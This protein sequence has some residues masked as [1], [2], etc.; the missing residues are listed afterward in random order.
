MGRNSPVGGFYIQGAL[1][2]TVLPSQ[3][4]PT[5]TNTHTACFFGRETTIHTV[6]HGVFVPVPAN[7]MHTQ[8]TDFS[9]YTPHAKPSA[10]P[11][12]TPSW[13]WQCHFQQTCQAPRS[14]DTCVVFLHLCQA[15]SLYGVRYGTLCTVR[16]VIL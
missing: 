9:S 15:C 3:N 14:A 16:T 12:D 5:S 2:N 6:I 13:C 10:C 8:A 4:R 7:S 1:K 11:H